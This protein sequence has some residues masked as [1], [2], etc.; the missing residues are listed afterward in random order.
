[1]KSYR[2]TAGRIAAYMEY[3]RQEERAAATIEKYRRDTEEFSLFLAGRGASKELAVKW[4]ERL[5]ER[6]LTAA[7]VN[8]KLSAVNGLFR[9]LGWEEC[10]VRF[11]RYPR[12]PGARGR[13][14]WSC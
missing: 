13:S 3:L 2:V 6:G 7:T 14:G 5:T 11:L 1:M 12:R 4:K 10:R 8:G 9:F